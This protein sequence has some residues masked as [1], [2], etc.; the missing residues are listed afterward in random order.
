VDEP[1]LLD[2]VIDTCCHCEDAKAPISR[3]N[4]PIEIALMSRVK[5]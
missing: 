5:Q 4:M 2:R 3:Q 1:D